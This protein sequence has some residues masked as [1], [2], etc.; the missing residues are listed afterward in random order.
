MLTSII[1][2]TYNN[3]EYTK[4]CLDS[5][6]RYTEKN[7]YEIVI[8]DNHSTDGTREWL[9]QQLDIKLIL[10]EQNLGFPKGCNQGIELSEGDN[11]LLLNNDVIVTENWLDNLVKCLYS[12][13]AIGA[14]G[15]VTNSAAYYT[16][17]QVP[18]LN[19]NEMH[20]FARD[21][22]KSN[23]NLWEERLKLIGYCML[24]KKEVVEKIGLLDE[25]FTPGNFEDDDYSIRIRK[26]GYKLILSK[27]TFIHHYG[28]VSWREDAN[29]YSK[30][31]SDNERKFKAKWGTSSQSYII[32]HELINKAK[33]R[34]EEKINILH[35]GCQAGATLLKLKNNYKNAGLYGIETNA[36]EAREA[37]SFAKIIV[38]D[39]EPALNELTNK[40]FD[41]IIVTAWDQIKHPDLFAEIL[42]DALNEDGLLLSSFDNIF[43]YSN[44]LNLLQGTKPHFGNFSTDLTIESLKDIL[45]EKRFSTIIT[46]AK[47]QYQEEI[48]RFLDLIS[49]LSGE[50][51]RDKFE[52]TKYI[53][54]SSKLDIT[55]FTSLNNIK[56]GTSVEESI[57]VLQSYSVKK[58]IDFIMQNFKEHVSY[59]QAM[60]IHNFALNNHDNVLPFLEKAYELDNTNQDT[61]YNIAF[62]LNAY[63]ETKLAIKYLNSVHNKD[64][65]LEELLEE[66][67]EAEKEKNQELIFLLR[68][69][70]H[71][72]TPEES[73]ANLVEIINE[74]ANTEDEIIDLIKTNTVHPEEMLNKVGIILFER[75]S[76]ENVLPFLNAAFEMNKTNDDTLFN[77]GFILSEF[78]EYRLG[79]S[80]LESI[81]NKDQDVTQLICNIKGAL[82]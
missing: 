49:S 21:Y 74:Q 10:N 50:G 4:Q 56:Q 26:A 53:F 1:I 78:G 44:I 17:I 30:L 23:S 34:P 37:S 28:S 29:L 33:F 16:A 69:V 52:T 5:I 19:I 11:I 58:V 75:Q 13:K 8:V 6:R 35:I 81:K 15:P 79:L 68:R 57:R 71:A 60:A 66:L 73:E 65:Q 39:V 3:L 76:Y 38:K 18:Y 12:D 40:K 77:L 54:E 14:V 24:I 82:V 70:E 55:L 59:L 64:A 31:L 27:D 61:I 41:L 48:K 22:N 7:T 2:L 62:I 20:E 32:H 80:Y 43:H 46:P 72:I 51:M 63:G 47:I 25:Q 67:L 9:Q 36:D 45:S 42:Y